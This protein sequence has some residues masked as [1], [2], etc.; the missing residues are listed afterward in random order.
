M[1]RSDDAAE[2]PPGKNLDRLRR[3]N[4]PMVLWRATNR[5]RG[6]GIKVL[7]LRHEVLNGKV[8]SDGARVSFATRNVSPHRREP[9]YRRKV[10]I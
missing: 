6:E 9:L 5:Y 4:A 10:E 8:D 7:L 1:S 3:T 2:P